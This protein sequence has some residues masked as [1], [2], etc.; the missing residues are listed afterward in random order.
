MA[1]ALL[2]QSH[3]D[4]A[5]ALKS[6]GVTV[7]INVDGQLSVAVSGGRP[8]VFR[9]VERSVLSAGRA[10][11][12]VR[13]LES[14]GNVVVIADKIPAPAREELTT[15]AVSWFDRRGHI[16]IMAEGLL[17]DAGVAAAR[18]EPAPARF[19]N[20]RTGV[21]V[22]LALLNEPKNPPA[23]AE[24]AALAGV[25]LS[26]VT[27]SLRTFR[28]LGLIHTDGAPV[29]PDLFWATSEHWHPRW[30]AV[31]APVDS[32]E[33]L[34]E[35]AEANFDDLDRAGWCLA[36]DSAASA[37]NAPIIGGDIGAR[38]WYVPNEEV[39][40]HLRWVLG[41]PTGAATAADFIAVAPTLAVCRLRRLLHDRVEPVEPLVAAALDLALDSARGTESLH[42][43]NP[44]QQARVW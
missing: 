17:I 26:G 38:Y 29:I 23:A 28:K 37:W 9:P 2:K 16:R 31:A 24:I 11:E 42:N 10:V 25:A 32:D 34:I 33:L 12:I 3:R 1:N 4:L 14:G 36:G 27:A 6:L 15:A 8:I 41:E 44:D 19:P 21:G 20:G 39:S 13:S 40:N 5:E 7:I 30:V 18:A 43:W 22:A 35:R